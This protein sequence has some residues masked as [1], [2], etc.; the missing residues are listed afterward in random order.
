MLLVRTKLDKSP[1]HGIGVFAD[2]PIKKGTVVW[3]FHQVVDWRLTKDQIA[4][5]SEACRLQVLRY[6]YREKFTGLHVLCG[7][8]ARYLNH[9][10]SPNC[11]DLEDDVGEGITVA[12]RDIAPGEELTCDYTLFD[13]DFIEGVRPLPPRPQSSGSAP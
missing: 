4:Q 6:C 1:L 7:D 3:R 9:S 8:D 13:L 11:L 12:A 10:W 2:E 5:L